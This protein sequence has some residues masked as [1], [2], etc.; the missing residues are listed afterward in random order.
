MMPFPSTVSSDSRFMAAARPRLP[1]RRSRSKSCRS[2]PLGSYEA[3]TAKVWTRVRTMNRDKKREVGRVKLRQTH[4]RAP[5]VVAF[6]FVWLH[7]SCAL[8]AASREAEWKKV[9]DAIRKGLPKSAIEVLDSVLA[10]A[11]RDKAYGEATKAVARKIV[12]EGSIQGN[13]PEE[14]I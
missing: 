4:S 3:G 12:L 9:D 2:S 6:L 13:K 7:L 14:K 11:L 10:G 8:M 1:T 5:L